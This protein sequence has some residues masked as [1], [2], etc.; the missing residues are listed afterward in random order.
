M[1]NLEDGNECGSPD[2]MQFKGPLQSS[3]ER[4]Q[5]YLNQF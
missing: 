3:S 4:F 2:P 5:F 1:E